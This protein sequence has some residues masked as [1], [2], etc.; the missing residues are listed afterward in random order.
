[1][2]W[3]LKI[4]E[5]PVKGAEI[6]LVNG[7]KVKVG[8][9]DACDIVI[10]DG[11]LPAVAFE[12]DVTEAGVSIIGSTGDARLLP[13]FEVASFGT[14]EVAVG[15][16][17][18]PWKALVR[19]KPA[20]PEAAEKPTEAGEPKPAEEPGTEEKPVEEAEDPKTGRKRHGCGCGCL[21]FV[22]LLALL[23]GF[24][25]YFWPKI[26]ERYPSA[27]EYRDRVVT[28][29]K[30]YGSSVWDWCRKL[31]ASDPKADVPEV[32]PAE[33][34][35][36]IAST[37]G[38]DLVDRDGAMLLK[39]NVKRR[40]ERL[41]IRALA[42]AAD[43]LVTFDLTDDETMKKSTDELLFVVTEG[44]LKAVSASN[45]VV[46]IEGYAPSTE[47][48]EH[49]IRSLNADVKGIER[50]ITAGVRVGGQPPAPVAKSS[51]VAPEKPSANVPGPVT[52]AP[53]VK[54]N[55]DYPIAGILSSP[56]PCVVL[57][58]GHRLAEGAQLGSATIVRIEADRLVLKDGAAEFEWK[59]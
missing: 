57:R 26:V 47:R 41:A 17:D 15:P 25:W 22:I 6:A 14:T 4:V 59:P 50:L 51:F 9:S 58:T 34:L 35:A 21:V 19:A 56:Y 49:A 20:E 10:A 28:C 33:T 46:E 44:A 36:S 8:S 55:R 40:T 32:P 12:L 38:L 30:S 3:L 54:A 29:G 42:L 27:D 48:L 37:Y 52:G 24:V 31:F 7:M 23:G 2:S 13:P 45:R 39:G 43:P 16:S 53:K 1:M 11:S 18:E 5:G